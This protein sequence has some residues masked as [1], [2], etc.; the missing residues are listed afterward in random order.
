MGIY[1]NS[2][3]IDHGLGLFSFYAHLGMTNVKKGQNIEKG[4]PVGRSGTSG[5]A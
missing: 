2:I 4:Q 3:I 5:L 1:G